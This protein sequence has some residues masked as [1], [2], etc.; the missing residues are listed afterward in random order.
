MTILTEGNLQ[1]TF[2]DDA[3]VMKFDDD[4]SHGL[5]HC[6]KAVD[7][8]V[9]LEDR[10]YFIEIKDFEHPRAPSKNRKVP[11][12][13]FQSGDLDNELVSEL[14]YKFRDSFLYEWACKKV[15]KP[16]DYWIL[17]ASQA[18]TKAH[19]GPRIDAVKPRLPLSQYSEKQWKRQ[20]VAKCGV[21]NI[22]TWNKYF[23]N[24]PV[25]K[26]GQ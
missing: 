21:F 14:V 19:L 26:I 15:D 5:S 12:K 24:Y 9:E 8:I 6:M 17:I 7:F 10:V 4:K 23:P 22:C 20:I 2:P 18:L 13:K 11:I 25:K 1:I 16:I 3:N